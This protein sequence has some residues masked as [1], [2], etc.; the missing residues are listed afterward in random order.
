MTLSLILAA[1]AKAGE[2]AATS[3]AHGLTFWERVI[4][5]G[6]ILFALLIFFLPNIIP[7]EKFSAGIFRKPRPF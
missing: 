7:S 6:F 4:Q 3:H 1:T 5:I 2:A